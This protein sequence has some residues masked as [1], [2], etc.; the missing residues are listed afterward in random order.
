[1]PIYKEGTR[2]EGN[3]MNHNSYSMNY[4]LNLS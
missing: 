1:M 3:E 4:M 2:F